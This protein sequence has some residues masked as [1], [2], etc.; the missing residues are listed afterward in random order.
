MLEFGS[1]TQ[2]FNM[3][4]KGL[5]RSA[6]W[7]NPGATKPKQPKRLHHT[8]LY[9]PRGAAKTRTKPAAILYLIRVAFFS[10]Q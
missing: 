2:R 6:F 3:R 1:K 5:R 4:T 10:K 8:A 7:A 9:Q